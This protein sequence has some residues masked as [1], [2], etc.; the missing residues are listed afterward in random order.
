MD[1]ESVGCDQLVQWEGDDAAGI[2]E[3]FP[4]GDG[5]SNSSA[6]SQEKH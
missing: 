3:P 4:A 1:H 5:V 6:H 2:M